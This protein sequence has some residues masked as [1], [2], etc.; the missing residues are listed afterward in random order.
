MF[1]SSLSWCR[2][3]G[4]RGRK[5][6]SE[7]SFWTN[8]WIDASS[9]EE[10][11]KITESNLRDDICPRILPKESCVSWIDLDGAKASEKRG[12][13]KNILPPEWSFF[14]HSMGRQRTVVVIWIP[15]QSN[16]RQHF[17][18]VE[19]VQMF[20]QEGWILEFQIDDTKPPFLFR[21]AN[22]IPC[23]QW[24]GPSIH[25]IWLSS[26]AVSSC[27]VYVFYHLFW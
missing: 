7:R 21:F 8:I 24:N 15:Y 25:L 5:K 10:K 14:L 17:F 9:F 2:A 19:F 27:P 16:L 6:L 26:E 23:C 3:C 18:V 20:H 4:E 22:F 11:E 13:T 1:E 12:K